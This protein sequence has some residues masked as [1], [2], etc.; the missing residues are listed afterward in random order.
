M[1][2][3]LSTLALIAC[4]ASS[5]AFAGDKAKSKAAPEDANAAANQHA[6]MTGKSQDGDK[7]SA[8]TKGKKKSKHAAPAPTT[9]E[10]QFE[11][12]LRGIYGG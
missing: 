9:Q 6:M 10:Q 3:K 12:V 2:T 5:F 7:A 4:L 8:A 11:E 1:K